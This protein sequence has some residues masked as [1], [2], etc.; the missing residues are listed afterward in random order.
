MAFYM[1]CSSL[2]LPHSWQRLGGF[3]SPSATAS[4]VHLMNALCQAAGW[5]TFPPLGEMYTG[6]FS[7][8][9]GICSPCL[10]VIISIIF[11]IILKTNIHWPH[12]VECL[13]GSC[14][15]LIQDLVVCWSKII[16]VNHHVS[17]QLDT[18]Y[19]PLFFHNSTIQKL[20][21]GQC[22]LALFL[23][24]ILQFLLCKVI[25]F[26][27]GNTEPLPLSVGFKSLT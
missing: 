11:P 23:D 5:L 19:F 25:A 12:V 27:T 21:E 8:F 9:G 7:S 24:F 17:S 18:F 13:S 20:N 10:K 1:R 15:T 16:N 6:T 4:E 3:S 26:F 22:G 2:F 14:S